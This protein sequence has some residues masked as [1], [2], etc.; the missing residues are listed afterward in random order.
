MTDTN[1]ATGPGWLRA[2]RSVFKPRDIFLHD[3]RSLRRFRIGAGVQ[4]AAALIAFLL[5]A[6]STFATVRAVAA[7][8]GDVAVMRRQLADMETDLASMR[9]TAH[10]RAALL[11]RRQVFLARVLSGDADPAELAALM[12]PQARTPSDDAARAVAASFDRVEDMQAAMALQ[13]RAATRRRYQEAARAVRQVGLN[14]A[15]FHHAAD[16]VGGPYE[17]LTA[18]NADPDYRALFMSWRRLDQLEQGVAAIPSGKPVTSAN[19][20][21]GFGGRSDPFRHRSAFHPGIDLAGPVGTPIYAT[22]DGIVSRSEYNHGGYG[23]MIEINHGQ[24]ISTRYGHMSRRI[25]QVG[26][27]VHRG[28]LIGLMGST[29]RSTGSHVHYEVRIDGQ[30]VNPVPFLQTGTTLIALQ[31]R[32]EGEQAAVGGPASGSR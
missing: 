15:R 1:T 24:G 19:F 29:G 21:S 12:P 22:A 13:A 32:L 2:L 26:Q 8:T 9:A 27:R 4:V 6:W 25:A 28:E 17:P 23:N 14:P 30:A 10:R 11:E 5:L 7:M 18:S 16:G 3:G 20:T 31:R